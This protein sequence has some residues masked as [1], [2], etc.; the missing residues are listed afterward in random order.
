[1]PSQCGKPALQR[2]SVLPVIR[3]ATLPSAEPHASP[4]PRGPPSIQS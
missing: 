2:V 4:L 1:M 3:Q